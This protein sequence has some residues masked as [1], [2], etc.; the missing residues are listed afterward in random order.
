LSQ[1]QSRRVNTAP[2]NPDPFAIEPLATTLFRNLRTA[3]IQ[4]PRACAR[5]SVDLGSMPRSDSSVAFS[6]A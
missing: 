4:V 5:W 6:F 1:K 3:A 2:P